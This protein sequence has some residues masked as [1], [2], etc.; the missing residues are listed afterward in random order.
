MA[1][2][3]WKMASVLNPLLVLRLSP[4]AADSLDVALTDEQDELGQF[5]RGRAT[6]NGID[7]GIEVDLQIGTV[8]VYVAEHLEPRAVLPDVLAE[9]GLT[10]ND[11]AQFWDGSHWHEGEQ[12]RPR[13]S[14]V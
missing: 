7:L 5:R 10:N 2:E 12:L 8:S 6:R 1:Q 11:V 4:G 3:G 9:L 13:S 14:A